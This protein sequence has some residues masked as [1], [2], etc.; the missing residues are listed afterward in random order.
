MVHKTNSILL[1]IVF[2]GI[3][4]G[5]SR[6]ASPLKVEPA[7]ANSPACYIVYDAGSSGTRLSIYQ[8]IGM[9]WLEHDGPKVS[10]LADP[11]REI[12]GKSKQ[13]IEPVANEII[14]ALDAVK[15]DGPIDKKGKPKWQAFDWSTQCQLVSVGI[16]ATAGMRI[17]EQQ[18]PSAS[19]ELW[20][21]VK[22]KLVEKL[23]SCRPIEGGRSKTGRASPDLAPAGDTDSGRRRPR[24]RRGRH[25]KMDSIRDE[26]PTAISGEPGRNRPEVDSGGRRATLRHPAS[27]IKRSKQR[28]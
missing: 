17:A 20:K 24:T 19:L 5:C 3:L 28:S 23:G 22:Q 9:N 1:F 16:Y 10:A 26:F 2:L 21:I 18:N 12:R 27:R 15:Q 11:V 13:D 25:I 8:K 7:S 14:T 4:A 6:Y